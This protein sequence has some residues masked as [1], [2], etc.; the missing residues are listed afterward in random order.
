MLGGLD[1]AA[2]LDLYAGSGAVGLEALSRGAADVL[3]VESDAGRGP[4]HQAEHRD[5]RPA[6]RTAGAGPGRPRA[7]PRARSGRAARSRLRRS[8]LLGGRRRAPQGADDAGRARL[9]G[10]GRAG[11]T[12]ARRQVRRA[13][14][15]GR[16]RQGPVQAL[17]RDDALVR[18]RVRSFARFWRTGRTD[19]SVSLRDSRGLPWV[20][21]PGHQ[22]PSGHHQPRGEAPRRGDRRRAAQ[23]VQ[24][25][26]V[27]RRRAGRAA[28]R[29]QQG[30][31]ERH[32]RP[33][34]TA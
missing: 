28:A 29:G 9:A 25:V 17:R 11:H 32:G 13:A 31:A 24:V 5:R 33:S 12:G 15:A 4:G 18:S 16:I 6:R 1:G 14:L 22:W 21:R 2:V 34:S 23:S 19:G 20:L 8:A 7:A 26:A 27:H 30:P 10:A 3:L